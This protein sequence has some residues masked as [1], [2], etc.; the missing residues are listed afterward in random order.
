M[1]TEMEIMKRDLKS[2][3]QEDVSSVNLTYVEAQYISLKGHPQYN[4]N[5]LNQKI[6]DDPS[7]LGL[8]E[9]AVLKRERP[10]PKAGRLDL[11]LKDVNSGRRYTVELQLGTVDESH[12][13]R[14][15]EYWDNERKRY[16]QIDHCAVI[17]AET[18][19]ARFLKVISL[20]NGHIPLIALQ[21]KAIQIDDK[22][23][24]TFT[25]VLDEVQLGLDTHDEEIPEVTR[26]YWEQKVST[27]AVNAVDKLVLSIQR[28]TGRFEIK[29]NKYYIG[30]VVAG[31]SANFVVFK[32][33]RGGIRLEVPFKLT[34][35]EINELE[36]A[37]I[38]VLDY[39]TYWRVHPLR[40]GLELASNPSD[41]LLNLM[42]RAYS[43]YFE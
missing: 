43:E 5:W 21:V 8:G 19:N 34:E 25:K 39:A 35:D 7:I 26:S 38:E 33:Q 9:L 40:I 42:K 1:L 10:Q 28:L 20:F 2:V 13:I 15:I 37:K 6:F 14:T 29:Y 16:P 17:C 3:K 41:I 32:P 24:L 11:L 31:R 36:K 18:I 23:A 4:E 12:I 30:C 22:I 27:E